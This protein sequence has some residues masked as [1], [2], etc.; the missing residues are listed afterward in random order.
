MSSFQTWMSYSKINPRLTFSVTR[1]SLHLWQFPIREMS[2]FQRLWNDEYIYEAEDDFID[3]WEEMSENQGRLE[4]STLPA[5]CPF[6]IRRREASRIRN[7]DDANSFR[8]IVSQQLTCFDMY[9]FT[10]DDHHSHAVLRKLCKLGISDGFLQSFFRRH[11]HRC[12]QSTDLS[13]ICF[14]LN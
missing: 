11:C 12:R 7:R 14:S 2:R 1:S 8:R 6:A 3:P 9:E 13:S 4:A 5:W 10:L